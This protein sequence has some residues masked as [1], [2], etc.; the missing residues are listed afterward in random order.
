MKKSSFTKLVL[1]LSLAVA[2]NAK[3]QNP[4][5]PTKDGYLSYF[6]NDS[7][8]IN[9]GY[10]PCEWYDY[11]NVM[12]GVIYSRD[13]IRIN[14]KRYFYRVPQPAYLVS[15]PEYHYLFPRQDTLFLREE[16]ET[17]RLYR[18][19]RNYFG[20]GETEKLISDMT[21]EVGDKFLYPHFDCLREDS[22]TVRRVSY[23]NGIKTIEF[24]EFYA[25]ITFHEGLFPTDFPL[26]QEPVEYGLSTDFSI[27]LCEYKD[28]E[29]VYG[30]PSGCY[31]YHYVDSDLAQQGGAVFVQ[32]ALGLDG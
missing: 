24:W 16:R 3:A 8:N 17:G 15:E 32:A 26:W 21:L 27:L 14:G 23:D 28:G 5:K 31:D 20:T 9:I 7:T 4:D 12:S 13:T 1:L 29:L 11:S 22:I 25:N 18:Y 10:I 19:Y 2:T 6:G 30:S